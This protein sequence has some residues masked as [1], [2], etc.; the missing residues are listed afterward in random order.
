[1]IKPTREKTKAV[2]YVDYTEFV[3]PSGFGLDVLLISGPY[4]HAAR[5]AEMR[6]ES[7]EA[8]AGDGFHAV[9]DSHF[10]GM[11]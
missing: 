11:I 8:L 3:S 2:K 9:R 5:T 7:R 1:L 4:L 6:R 10:N